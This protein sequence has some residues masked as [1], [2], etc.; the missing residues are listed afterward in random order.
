M[1]LYDDAIGDLQR[2]LWLAW[3]GADRAVLGLPDQRSLLPAEASDFL[4]V[5]LAYAGPEPDSAYVVIDLFR[6]GLEGILRPLRLPGRCCRV[7]A[8]LAEIRPP[9]S[10]GD[11]DFR[12]EP[13]VSF[14][15]DPGSEPAGSARLVYA[16]GTPS[17]P[18]LL[19]VD[20][21]SAPEQLDRDELETFM[22]HADRQDI[23]LAFAIA[24]PVRPTAAADATSGASVSV[25]PCTT[26]HPVESWLLTVAPLPFDREI[27][28]GAVARYEYAVWSHTPTITAS[29]S[30]GVDV[31]MGQAEAGWSLSGFF[32]VQVLMQRKLA[33]WWEKQLEAA[34]AFRRQAPRRDGTAGAADRAA[35]GDS[36]VHVTFEDVAKLDVAVAEKLDPL[37]FEPDETVVVVPLD[38]TSDRDA[39][40]VHPPEEIDRGGKVRR[41][42]IDFQIAARGD[43]VAVVDRYRSRLSAL[44]GTPRRIRAFQVDRGAL[45]PV[46]VPGDIEKEVFNRLLLADTGRA[47]RR[48]SAARG[49][50]QDRLVRDPIRS[51]TEQPVATLVR[52]AYERLSAELRRSGRTP[53]TLDQYEEDPPATTAA[54]TSDVLARIAAGRGRRA[55]LA[56]GSPAFTEEPRAFAEAFDK[57]PRFFARALAQ[58]G[59]PRLVAQVEPASLALELDLYRLCCAHDDGS[60]LE[61][62]V[63]AC[64]EYRLRGNTTFQELLTLADRVE[65]FS[66]ALENEDVRLEIY[67]DAT[68]APALSDYLATRERGEPCSAAAFLDFLGTVEA[69]AASAERQHAA[70]DRDRASR[71]VLAPGTSQRARVPDGAALVG[72][73]DELLTDAAGSSDPTLVEIARNARGR[74]TSGQDAGVVYLTTMIAHLE[75]HLGRDDNLRKLAA[76]CHALCDWVGL[77]PAGA[78]LAPEMLL[79]LFEGARQDLDRSG[80]SR[81]D[82]RE[83][84]PATNLAGAIARAERAAAEA[85]AR[86]FPGG[87]AGGI[88]SDVRSALPRLVHALALHWAHGAL[89]T[90]RRDPVATSAPPP[91]LARRMR[92]WP[93]DAA[94]T[95]ARHE[96]WV[97]T[98]PGARRMPSLPDL[99]T[100][101]A[102]SA[103]TG[104]TQAP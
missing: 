10:P 30:L 7:A 98:L 46:A 72:S 45:V 26:I 75:S 41:Y 59:L 78:R 57:E 3:D 18:D 91:D 21:H 55:Q 43:F 73:L 2:Q 39:I 24:V 54:T 61:A 33:D 103:E 69:A 4:V 68:A 35:S 92:L 28:R 47:T 25:G 13:V 48:Q 102:P 67:G 94:H 29:V 27:G 36:L 50:Q 5:V 31:P 100:A 58:A 63:S 34:D 12:I 70:A 99:A 82:G 74:L 37:P 62:L 1:P 90:L 93:L 84:E 89:E 80:R 11:F 95:W 96:D 8:S 17:G 86:S 81:G 87:S 65:A 42:R 79:K 85:F 51:V 88:H 40:A 49:S 9:P 6:L 14:T 76:F 104:A 64:A 23:P 52:L 32:A 53:P 38:G 101:L 66:L 83:L 56:L 97:R 22:R 77:A 19:G 16:T 44:D 20:V 15:L 60:R 71:A